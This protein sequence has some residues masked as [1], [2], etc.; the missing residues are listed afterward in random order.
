[1]RPKSEWV[2][3]VVHNRLEELE[4]MQTRMLG[5]NMIVPNKSVHGSDELVRE[6][7]R[8][9]WLRTEPS[10]VSNWGKN[11]V[12]KHDGCYP[13]MVESWER[14]HRTQGAV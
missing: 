2:A 7:H 3:Q 8:R 14:P 4:G 12:G 10:Y 5:Q 9:W 6:V 11:W 13:G 1:M